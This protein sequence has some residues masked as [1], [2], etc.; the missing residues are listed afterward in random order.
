MPARLLQRPFKANDK[1]HYFNTPSLW[2]GSHMRAPF[3]L[4]V[5]SLSRWVLFCGGAF[6]PKIIRA[7]S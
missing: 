1:I 4:T 6:Y 3:L 2:R 5:E 7:K